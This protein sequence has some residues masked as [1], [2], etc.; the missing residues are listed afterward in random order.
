METEE[1]LASWYLLDVD[2]GQRALEMAAELP[3]AV[4]QPTG[5]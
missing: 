5:V 3:V 2:S 1:Y 4:Y